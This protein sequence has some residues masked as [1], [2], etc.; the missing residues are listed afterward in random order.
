MACNKHRLS[1]Y[2]HLQEFI[3]RVYCQRP[4]QADFREGLRRENKAQALEF[5][6]LNPRLCAVNNIQKKFHQFISEGLIDFIPEV[7]TCKGHTNEKNFVGL[8]VNNYYIA[9]G[10]ETNEA[11]SYFISALEHA[12]M[13][14]PRQSQLG[15]RLEPYSL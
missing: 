7:R 10:S 9:C 15:G 3:I 14:Y 12:T 2:N 5:K 6:V 8:T 13:K 11:G 1:I 4:Q